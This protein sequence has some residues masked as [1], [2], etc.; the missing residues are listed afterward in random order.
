[1]HFFIVLFA[2][3]APWISKW[4]PKV[5]LLFLNSVKIHTQSNLIWVTEIYTGVKKKKSFVDQITNKLCIPTTVQRH[6]D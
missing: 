1:M 4:A 5:I 3:M 6:V 2:Y